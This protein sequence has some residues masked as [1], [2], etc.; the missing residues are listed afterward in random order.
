MRSVKNKISTGGRAGGGNDSQQQQQQRTKEKKDVEI[1]K[2]KNRM[3]YEG[4][5]RERERQ[6][7]INRQGEGDSPGCKGAQ[8][9]WK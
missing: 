4:Q 6:S 2:K 8:E 5:M 1:M 3:D 9:V 7:E